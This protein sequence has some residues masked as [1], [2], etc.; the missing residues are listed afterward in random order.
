MT[1]KNIKHQ[2]IWEK[3]KKTKQRKKKGVMVAGLTHDNNVLIGFS[4]CHKNDRYDYFR[5]RKR[6]ENFGIDLALLRAQ[7]WAN[8]QKSIR[9]CEIPPDLKKAIRSKD[10]LLI[11]ETIYRPLHKFIERCRKYY[12]NAKGLPLWTVDIKGKK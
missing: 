7:K 10:V 3:D 4:L 11:P 6:K 12:K 8:C 2:Y 1:L 5:K 9:N